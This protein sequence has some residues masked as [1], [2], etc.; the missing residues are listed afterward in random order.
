MSWKLFWGMFGASLSIAAA[1]VP[2]IM[3]VLWW[4]TVVAIVVIYIIVAI[5]VGN[6]VHSADMFH[7][8]KYAQ[9]EHLTVLVRLG[10]GIF[11]TWA[12][13]L[14]AVPEWWPYL[15][16]AMVIIV[17][18]TYW[19]CRWEEWKLNR[20]EREATPKPEE[21]T[22]AQQLANEP[23]VKK[24]RPILNRAGHP[25]VRVLGC[26]EI[27]NEDGQK[28]ATQFLVQTPATGR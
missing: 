6:V 4:V 24:F 11:A 1:V 21:M 2:T 9:R 20:P 22:P 12:A 5:A 16:P 19:A 23:M 10:V 7:E 18:A 26:E 13:T 8:L 15:A 28:T 27:K 3:G 25:H 14:A 17:V